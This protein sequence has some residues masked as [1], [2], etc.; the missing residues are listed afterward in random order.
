MSCPLLDGVKELKKKPK[1]HE[2][3]SEGNLSKTWSLAPSTAPALSLHQW[4]QMILST[5]TQVLVVLK[6]LD[7]FANFL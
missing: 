7:F 1:G 4:L 2:E 5:E 6:L 3:N